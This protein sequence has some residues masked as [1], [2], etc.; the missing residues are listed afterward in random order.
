MAAMATA[1]MAG[2][3]ELP[4]SVIPQ[5]P[6]A[7]GVSVESARLAIPPP[8]FIEDPVTRTFQAAGDA[9]EEP[10]TMYPTRE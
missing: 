1:A 2:A 8:V 10:T 4:P 7:A 6:P 3:A 9:W 5:G